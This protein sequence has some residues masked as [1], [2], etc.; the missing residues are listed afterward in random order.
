MLSSAKSRELIT[1][2]IEFQE[3]HTIQALVFEIC[4]ELYGLYVV[5]LHVKQDCAILIANIDGYSFRV[6]LMG[7]SNFGFGSKR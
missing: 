6:F 4:L 3:F 5:F 2:N 7:A 1:F